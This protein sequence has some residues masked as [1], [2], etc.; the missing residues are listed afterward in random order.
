MHGRGRVFL[1]SGGEQE[2]QMS[3][4]HHEKPR[5]AMVPIEEQHHESR[6][7]VAIA[8]AAIAVAFVL[9][10]AVAVSSITHGVKTATTGGVSPTTTSAPETA[11]NGHRS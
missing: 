10:V 11:G 2:V 9:S 8:M 5:H 3:S 7:M 6:A 4:L 1:A